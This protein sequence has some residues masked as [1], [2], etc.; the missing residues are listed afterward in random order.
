MLEPIQGAH[1][2]NSLQILKYMKN[3][4]TLSIEI[5]NRFFE[6]D[7]PYRLDMMNAFKGNI[8]KDSDFLKSPD[9]IKLRICAVEA[10]RIVQRVFVQFMGL[11]VNPQKE[12][13]NSIIIQ[14]DDVPI[15]ALG[16]LIVDPQKL[17]DSEKDILVKVY[18]TGNKSTAHI[19]FNPK[20]NT[21]HADVLLSGAELIHKLLK[22][23]LF[24]IVG[25]EM[26]SYS[27]K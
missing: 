17:S 15:T 18:I 10:S 26:K 2:S 11:G 12:L 3:S 21:G 27:P 7:L 23:N 19:T 14:N 20:K 25:R 4:Q 9:A 5:V 24:D 22:E 13:I 6:K 1:I 16:G 8:W